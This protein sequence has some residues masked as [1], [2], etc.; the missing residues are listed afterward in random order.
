LIGYDAEG[1]KEVVLSTGE[2]ERGVL[3]RCDVIALL[4]LHGLVQRK[5]RLER[6]ECDWKTVASVARNEK[7]VK[8]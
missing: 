8:I 5:V 7:W 2:E 4:K 6:K 3:Y 1:H